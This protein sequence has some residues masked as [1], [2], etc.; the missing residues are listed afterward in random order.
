M[1]AE[2]GTIHTPK[3]AIVIPILNKLEDTLECLESLEKHDY[4]AFEII[5]VDNGSTD[6]SPQ[7]IHSRYPSVWIV[8]NGE[9]LGFAEGSNRGI[10]L[11]MTNGAEVV[12]LLNNDTTVAPDCLLNLARAA[13]E[14]PENSVLGAKIVYYS[15]PDKIW[16]FGSLWDRKRFELNIVAENEPAGAWTE[17]V[18]R[19]DGSRP[20]H[21]V[22]H[23]DS[24]RGYPE[25]RHV[26][27]A[28][29]S[30]LR[31]NRLVLQGKSGRDPFFQ[32][33]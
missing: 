31:G 30:Q 16:H 26:R 22:C 7:I 32:H 4:P 6:S 20:H 5:I 19:T 18:D 11:A 12:F 27:S 3:V 25:D 15:H 21:R 14:L 17:R 1:S 2:S 24:L 29:F 23:V 8:E 28:F 33:P 9:N 10:E 13:G